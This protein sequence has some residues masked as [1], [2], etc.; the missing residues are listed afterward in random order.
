LHDVLTRPRIRSRYDVAEQELTELFE[1]LRSLASST[2]LATELPV[3]VRDEKDRQI[4]AAAIGGR[5]D[6][7]VTGD[8]DLLVLAGDPRLGALQIVT[9][10]TFLDRLSRSTQSGPIPGDS[11]T[12]PSLARGGPA[13]SA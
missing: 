9:A 3:D 7:L 12:G 6:Y 8:N 1:D 5:A 2:F 11:V 13:A 10:R 4:L